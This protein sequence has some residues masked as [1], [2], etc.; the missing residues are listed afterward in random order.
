MNECIPIKLTKNL[1]LIS[2]GTNFIDRK[3]ETFPH[4]L[5]LNVLGSTTRDYR[6]RS[7]SIDIDCI[8]I[9]YHDTK[10]SIDIS[11]N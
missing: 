6:G 8:F 10:I 4:L 7:P 9:V 11:H 3:A 5:E 2:N 1:F